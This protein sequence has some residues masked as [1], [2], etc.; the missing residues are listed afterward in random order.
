MQWR[1]SHKFLGLFAF[2]HDRSTSKRFLLAVSAFALGTRTRTTT[3]VASVSIARIVVGATIVILV[4]VATILVGV[5]DG[6]KVKRMK[7]EET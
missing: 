5:C 4:V 3:V 2:R 7:S 1:F 6:L